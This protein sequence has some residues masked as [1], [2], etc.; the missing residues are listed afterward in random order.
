[1]NCSDFKM[2]FIEK[3]ICVD[4]PSD[5][6]DIVDW[7]YNSEKDDCK[8]YSKIIKELDENEFYKYF[9]PFVYEENTIVEE[10]D[11]YWDGEILHISLTDST[12]LYKFYLLC[13][14][15]NEYIKKLY[16]KYKESEK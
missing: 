14:V 2:I 8:I 3:D 13:D 11:L 9:K 6:I 7:L 5:Y 4:S 16:N 10:S 1:M 12:K 15:D